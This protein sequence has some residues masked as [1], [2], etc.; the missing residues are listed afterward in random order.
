MK[1]AFQWLLLFGAISVSLGSPQADRNQHY[2]VNRDGEFDKSTEQLIPRFE[3]LR[4]GMTLK[5]VK[6]L[7]PEPEQARWGLHSINRHYVKEFCFQWQ[8]NVFFCFSFLNNRPWMEG[9]PHFPEDDSDEWQLQC[10]AVVREHT[11]IEEGH[12]VLV[13]QFDTPRVAYHYQN[14]QKAQQADNG[15]SATRPDSKPE[16]KDKPQLESEGRSR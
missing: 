8:E 11:R 15:Q 13:K 7:F 16:E 6:R 12:E 5:D 9:K 3:K 1:T 4:Y 10:A 14:P 2:E